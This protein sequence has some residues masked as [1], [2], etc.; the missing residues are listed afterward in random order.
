MHA[1]DGRRGNA[2]QQE[3]LSRLLSEVQGPR[4]NLGPVLIE[5]SVNRHRLHTQALKGV[6]Q[7]SR[8]TK[9]LKER[10]TSRRWARRE[11][12]VQDLSRR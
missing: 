8:P 2:L 11:G 9:N 12:N 10:P 6:G 3:G 7:P 4:I 1:E 5:G